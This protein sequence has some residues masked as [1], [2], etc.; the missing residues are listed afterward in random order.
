MRIIHTLIFVIPL[1]RGSMVVVF[2]WEQVLRP[3]H[4]LQQSGESADSV[5]K[6]A[7]DYRS[8]VVMQVCWSCVNSIRV[9]NTNKLILLCIIANHWMNSRVCDTANKICVSF[10]ILYV[11]THTK[12]IKVYNQKKKKDNNNYVN[13]SSCNVKAHNV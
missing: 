4:L 2:L 10:F 12:I 8:A 13:M 9:K 3:R 5:D 7:D 6:K 1:L 11:L